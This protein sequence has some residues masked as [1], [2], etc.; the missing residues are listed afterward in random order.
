MILFSSKSGLFW[1]EAD[2]I[3]LACAS[4]V[5]DFAFGLYSIDNTNKRFF[6][7]ESCLIKEDS[8]TSSVEPSF[9]V[10]PDSWYFGGTSWGS[11][12]I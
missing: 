12:K 7:K 3:N 5:F 1:L 6:D 10:N 8:N 2:I 11:L 9:S 4:V